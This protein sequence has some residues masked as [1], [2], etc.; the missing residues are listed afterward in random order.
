MPPKKLMKVQITLFS[1]ITK[2]T[3]RLVEVDW[4]I[5]KPCQGNKHAQN[6]RVKKVTCVA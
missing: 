2:E 6:A 1:G 3:F 5:R 4:N